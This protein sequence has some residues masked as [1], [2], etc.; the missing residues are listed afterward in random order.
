MNSTYTVSVGSCHEMFLSIW[1]K[2]LEIQG[3]DKE[4][5]STHATHIGLPQ[6]AMRLLCGGVCLWKGGDWPWL[7]VHQVRSTVGTKYKMRLQESHMM[8]RSFV[9]TSL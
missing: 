1:A 5:A 4:N 2:A 8:M 7:F 6:S 3:E 9:M